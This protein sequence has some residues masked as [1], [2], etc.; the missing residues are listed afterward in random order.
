MP[1]NFSFL[2][3]IQAQ[4]PNY[5]DELKIEPFIQVGKSGIKIKK[6]NRGKFTEYCGGT[7]TS[8]C[9]ARGKNSSD[10]AV[11]K[12]ATFAANARKWKH[13]EGGYFQEGGTIKH[14]FAEYSP[15]QDKIIY[16]PDQDDVVPPQFIVEQQ[17]KIQNEEPINNT[18]SLGDLISPD[19]MI[20]RSKTNF[21]LDAAVQFLTQN[22][23]E[24][25]TKYCA[26]SVRKALEAG[27]LD[28]SDRPSSAYLYD[29]VLGKLGFKTIT[30]SK[31]DQLPQGYTPQKGDIVVIGKSKSHPHGHIAMYNGHQWI[32]DF[33]QKTWHGLI[34][35]ENNNYTIWRHE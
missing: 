24:K 8:A 33:K 6:K 25:S 7:V 26:R 28:L 29:T 16:V 2:D 31:G 27:G 32:S 23:K 11:R 4:M 1:I 13:K 22:A 17:Q 30:Q 12:R 21:N 5:Y 20:R 14:G 19:N 34:N 18:A 10:P 9:I 3:F 15:F 35:M